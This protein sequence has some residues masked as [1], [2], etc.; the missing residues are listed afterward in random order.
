M[1]LTQLR[2]V[3]QAIQRRLHHLGIRTVEDLLFL[4]PLRYQDRTRI[5]PIADLIPSL[6]QQVEGEIMGNRIT[7]GRRRSLLVDIVDGQNSRL[8]LRFFHF[9]SHQQRQFE[10]GRRIRCFAQVHLN[11][12]HLEM[13]HPEYQLLGSNSPSLPESL[14]PIYPL[15]EGLSQ[16]RIQKLIDQAVERM[17]TGDLNLIELLPEEISAPLKLPSLQ[18]ALLEI[19]RPDNLLTAQQRE[20]VGVGGQRRLIIEELLA[21]QIAVRHSRSVVQRQQAVVLADT[22][23]QQA[24]IRQLPFELTAAQHRVIAEINRDLE[25]PQPMQRLLLGDVGSGKTIIAALAALNAVEGGGQCALMAPTELLAGQHLHSMKQWLNPLN[26]HCTLLSGKQGVRERAEVMGAICSGEAK[27]VVGTHALFQD[28][29]H[30]HQLHLLIIDEQHRFGVHQRLALRQ[31]G[32]SVDIMPHQL[33]MTATP[34]PRTLAMSAYADLDL[35]ILDQS[36]AGRKPIETVVLSEDRRDEV[37]QRI[38]HRLL[39][40]DQAYWV[41]P[42]I[43][44][45]EQLQCQAAED[46]WIQL[47][48][49]LPHHAIG[50]VHGRMKGEEKREVMRRFK[51]G[52][53]QL[54]VATTVIEVGV[55][56]AN[57][58]LMVIE[59]S[60]RLGLAQLHQLRGRVGRGAKQSHCLLLYHSP[61]GK[62]AK[63]R[64][65]ALREHNDGF[66]IA[67][68]D[69]AIRGPGELLG[70]RQTGVL[71]YRIADLQRDGHLLEQCNQ[72][73]DILLRD[74]PDQ[75]QQLIQ[76]WLDAG[77]QYAHV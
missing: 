37:V 65:Q 47:Q 70:T 56:V 66:K 34:I 38:D 18:Q 63:Q 64:L 75:A 77:V 43:E 58:T 28:D 73:A 31:K 33:V 1:D 40:G 36:P 7:F 21:H 45:S 72:M 67:E 69:L 53:L 22:T 20:Q 11:S 3:G 4:L 32:E 9:N 61:L 48:Q 41:C 49:L 6:D 74:Y 39:E 25:R 55:D 51:A 27:V 42:L 30:F 44:T 29:V 10:G 54:L 8:T 15:T 12:G 13:V 46:S 60:E 57:A 16:K 59:N 5:T 62:V 71:Q 50:L 14:T 76:R 35:S 23:L 19:H 26:I 68:L 17:I 24:L 2:G 52:E